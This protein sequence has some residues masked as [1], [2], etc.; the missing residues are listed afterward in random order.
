MEGKNCEWEL[1]TWR[2]AKGKLQGRVARSPVSCK[3]EVHRQAYNKM[4]RS[5]LVKE[6]LERMDERGNPPGGGVPPLIHS[7]R[8]ACRPHICARSL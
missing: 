3:L 7:A 5:E 2:R 1:R 8:K 4:R 6:R